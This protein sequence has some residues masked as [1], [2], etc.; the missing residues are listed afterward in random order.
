EDM[1]EYLL[2][3]MEW[4][5]PHRLIFI[6]SPIAIRQTELPICFKSIYDLLKNSNFNRFSYNN[7]IRATNQKFPKSIKDV[8]LVFLTNQFLHNPPRIADQHQRYEEML[9]G[10]DAM[11]QLMTLLKHKLQ[12]NG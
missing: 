3:E 6:S 4:L 8:K 11:I 9:G 1:W 10:M 5:S 12:I 2:P 7:V